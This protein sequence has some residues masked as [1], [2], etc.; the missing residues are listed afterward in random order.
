MKQIERHNK[1]EK[2]EKPLTT[3]TIRISGK[4]RNLVLFLIIVGLS[5]IIYSSALSDLIM[6]VLHREGSSHGLFIPFISAIILWGKRQ[7]IKGL[8]LKLSLLPGAMIVGAGLLI[9]YIAGSSTENTLPALSFFVMLAGLVMAIFG[10]K[11]FKEVSFPLF[12]LI[13]MIPLPEPVYARIS[14]W[15]RTASTSGSTGILQLFGM[16]L[17]REGYNIYLPN[18]NIYV[19][20][21]C[22]GIRYLISYFV[23]G[24]A[25]AFVYGKGAKSRILLIVATIPISVV[26]GMV[27]LAVIFLSAHYIGAFMAGHHAHILL[28]WFVFAFILIGAILADRKRLYS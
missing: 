22:S 14:E 20:E 7:K 19:A 5:L 27:R 10:M 16:P 6:S 3:K 11:V 25:Y 4:Y 21:S 15:M 28:S 13:T 9:F 23:F 8:E 24:L 17:H 1:K 2:H 18:V 12:F 26:A